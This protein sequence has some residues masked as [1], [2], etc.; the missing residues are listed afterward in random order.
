VGASSATTLPGI[1]RQTG[2]DGFDV[3]AE[4][5]NAAVSATILPGASVDE[6]FARTHSGGTQWFVADG[7]ESV[8]ALADSAG[9]MTAQYAYEPFGRTTSQGNASTNTF[10]YTGREQ[11]SA[12]ESLLYYRARFYSAMYQRFIS[13]DPIEFEGGLNLYAYVHNDPISFTDPYGTCGGDP[14]LWTVDLSGFVLR[15]SCSSEKKMI[16]VDAVGISRSLRYFQTP[17]GAFCASTGV[18]ASTSSST[19]R[20]C[21]MA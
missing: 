19:S 5:S 18:A 6:R 13:E 21:S 7:A 10:S 4:L 17:V 8:V 16:D 9:V 15:S 1:S 20:K 3:A 12:S 2:Y 14:F 11:V